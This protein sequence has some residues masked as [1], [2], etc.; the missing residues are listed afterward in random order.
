MLCCSQIVKVYCGIY[1][2]LRTYLLGDSRKNEL[3][4]ARHLPFFYE[5]F[6]VDVRTKKI[7][8]YYTISLFDTLAIVLVCRHALYF[9]SVPPCATCAF[10]IRCFLHGHMA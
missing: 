5:Q 7:I 6:K 1:E 8:T 9:L 4:L 2:L 10:V 3:Y